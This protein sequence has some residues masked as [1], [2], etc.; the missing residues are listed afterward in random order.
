MGATHIIWFHDKD[1][2]GE[3]KNSAQMVY[4]QK[5]LGGSNADNTMFLVLLLSELMKGNIVWKN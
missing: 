1:A 3:E 4:I 2:I 5:I